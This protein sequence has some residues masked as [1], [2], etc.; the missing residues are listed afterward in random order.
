MQTQG[1]QGFQKSQQAEI[2]PSDQIDKISDNFQAN[3]L[4]IFDSE[5]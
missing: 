5:L 1:R 3:P 4:L 2:P